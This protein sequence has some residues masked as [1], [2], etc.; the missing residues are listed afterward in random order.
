L[1]LLTASIVNMVDPEVIVFG[2]GMVEAMGEAFLVPI[3]TAAYQY[4]IKQADAELVRIVPAALGD[5]S[6]ILGAAVHARRMLS[7]ENG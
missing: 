7:A 1:G 6:A 4:F 3:R 5:H 2:G